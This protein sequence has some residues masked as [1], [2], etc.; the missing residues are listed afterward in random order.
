MEFDPFGEDQPPNRRVAPQREAAL[1]RGGGRPGIDHQI[2]RGLLE[3]Q[4]GARH[5]VIGG[6]KPQAAIAFGTRPSCYLLRIAD[7]IGGLAAKI[8][9]AGCEGFERGF[10]AQ[11][12]REMRAFM[13]ARNQQTVSFALCQQGRGSRDP[14]ARAG[15][16]GDAIGFEV[17]I[18]TMPRDMRQK[19]TE[20]KTCGDQKCDHHEPSGTP[21]HVRLLSVWATVRRETKAVNKAT[22]RAVR[23]IPA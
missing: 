9:T 23:K 13:H 21:D 19:K 4:Q 18:S 5:V 11:E 7:G 14:F 16:N 8:K 10:D 15:Q 20:I 22:R 6:D 3:F 2:R 1:M 17:G 12:I